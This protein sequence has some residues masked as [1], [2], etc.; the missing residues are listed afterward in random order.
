MRGWLRIAGGVA[1]CAAVIVPARGTVRRE[2]PA[3]TLALV[4][5]TVIDGTGA[6]PRPGMTVLVRGSRIA[7]VAPDGA[8]PL[9]PGARVVDLRGRYLIP[10]LIDAHVHMG[11]IPRPPE[12]ARGVLRAA[13]LGGVTSVRDMGGS[14]DVVG[15]LARD[16]ARNDFDSPRIFY[17]AIMAGPGGWFEGERGRRM[18]GAYPVGEAPAVR[19]VDAATD[20]RRVIA[21][22]KAAG[23]SGIKVYNTV[24]PA[25]I[26]RLVAEAHRQGLR[27]WSHLAVDPGR[28]GE[29]V[30]AGVDVVSHGDMFV[31]EVMP[32]PRPGATVEE[33]RAVRDSVVR[34]TPPGSAPFS[35]VL[36]AMRR[37]GTILDATLYIIAG[38]AVDTAGRP[39]ERYARLLDFAAAMVRRADSAGVPVAA[40]TDHI[41]G[42][43]PNIHAELQ[44]LVSRAGLTP[45][46]ALRAATSTGARAIGAQD[47]LGTVAPGKVADLVVLAAD[48]SRDIRNTQT[49]VMVLKGG[50]VLERT[51][52]WRP[53]PHASP[54]SAR[55]DVRTLDSSAGAQQL[56]GHGTR[57]R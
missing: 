34:A 5:A 48:P 33:Q 28:P 30:A 57:S 24:D 16:G 7:A 20:V 45:L 52:P 44:L 36:D 18:A 19:R 51:T 23:V 32:A 50:R 14:L 3:E 43:T 31:G 22:A 11:T 10:G 53:G 39:N 1:A 42:S 4:H 8:R 6:P 26:R 54:P 40:G 46:E 47:S 2:P 38:A 21:E 49:V 27:A 41:G 35:A 17:S 12:V 13:L 55:A 15:P 29:V 9:P 37:R 25:L 56:A